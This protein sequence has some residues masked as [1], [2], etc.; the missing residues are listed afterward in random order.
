MH[1]LTPDPHHSVLEDGPGPHLSPTNSRRYSAS[2][3]GLCAEISRSHRIAA[4][5]EPSTGDTLLKY[6]YFQAFFLGTP[7]S[8]RGT[9]CTTLCHFPPFIIVC[10][11]LVF[12][13][14]MSI[15]INIISDL[16]RHCRHRCCRSC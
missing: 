2:L 10:C 13:I 12:Y 4:E 16:Q 1:L 15:L 5:W 11:T 9:S 3:V 14:S 6:E 7:F 8:W